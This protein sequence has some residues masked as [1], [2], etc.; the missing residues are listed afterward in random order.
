MYVCQYLHLRFSLGRTRIL[1]HLRCFLLLV[2]MDN[3]A[4]NS[5]GIDPCFQFLGM[6]L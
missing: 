2:D 4:R 3:S 6:Y 5:V 1:G